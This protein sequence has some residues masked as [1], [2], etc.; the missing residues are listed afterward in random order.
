MKGYKKQDLTDAVLMS[1]YIEYV[2]KVLAREKALKEGK[3]LSQKLRELID[4]WLR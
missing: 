3:T 2:K 4:K 1:F